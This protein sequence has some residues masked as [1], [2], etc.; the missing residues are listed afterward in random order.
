VVWSEQ[1]NSFMTLSI[2]FASTS[3][4][5][6]LSESLHGPWSLP[7]PLYDFPAPFN[8]TKTTFCYAAKIHTEIDVHINT[9]G[10]AFAFSYMCNTYSLG[11]LFQPWEAQV[12]VPQ[13]IRA[14]LSNT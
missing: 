8:E 13:I 2:P 11:T 1:L 5:V 3:V 10:F 9:D 6:Q 12:Y 7:I 4:F 14:A